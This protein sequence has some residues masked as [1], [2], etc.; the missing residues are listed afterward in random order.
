[1][2][3]QPFHALE[4]GSRRRKNTYMTLYNFPEPYTIIFKVLP[5]SRLSNKQ[6]CMYGKTPMVLFVA[7]KD[8]IL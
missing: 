8:M 6:E 5:E 3:Y 4:L 2:R 7:Y 1:M